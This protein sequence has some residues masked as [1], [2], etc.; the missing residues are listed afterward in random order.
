MPVVATL[1]FLGRAEEALNLYR[2]ALGSETLFLVRFRD[3]PDKSFMAS[4]G[5]SWKINVPK[6]SE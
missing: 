3:S 5:V 2:E 1:N 6:S 4:V